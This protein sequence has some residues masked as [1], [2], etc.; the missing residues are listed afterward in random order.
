MAVTTEWQTVV[1]GMVLAG[2]VYFDLL[3]KRGRAN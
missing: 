3:R 1:T 2:A